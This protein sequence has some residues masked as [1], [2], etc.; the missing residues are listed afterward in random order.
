MPNAAQPH[1]LP[2]PSWANANR[3]TEFLMIG[4]SLRSAGADPATVL[5][6]LRSHGLTHILDCRSEHSDEA[7][8]ATYA[9]EVFYHRTS[10]DN[11]PGQWFDSGVG[12]A[13]EAL[14]QPDAVLLTHC[15]LGQTRGPS[16]GFA[17]LIDRGHDPGEA[18]RLITAARPMA[19]VGYAEAALRWHLDRTG[20]SQKQRTAAAMSLEN[21]R[22]ERYSRRRSGWR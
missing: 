8:V 15:S 4:G 22:R 19:G 18:L 11:D 5:R 17:I 12:F 13:R 10:S 21:A 2:Q 3:V 7:L 9:P 6:E 1:D 14:A 20:A 16:M